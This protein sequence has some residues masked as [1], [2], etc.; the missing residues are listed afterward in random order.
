MREA[1]IVSTARTPIGKA[2][3]GA[4]NMTE[5]PVLGAHVVNAVIERA[6]IDPSRIGDSFWGAGNQWGTQG[7]NVGRMTLFAAGV[8]NSVPAFSLDRKCGSGLTAV[9]M[10]ARAIIC[11]EMDVALAGGMESISLTVTKDAPRHINRS[12]IEHVPHAYMPMIETAEIV[13]ERYHISREAQDAFGAASQQRAVAATD[14]GRLD[15]EIVPITV[16]KQLYEKDGSKAGTETV[17]VSRDEGLRAGTTAEALAG[18]KTAFSPALEVV[19]DRREVRHAVRVGLAE[20]DADL[21]GVGADGRHPGDQHRLSPTSCQTTVGDR[22]PASRVP[23]PTKKGREPS[24]SSGSARGA[25][26]R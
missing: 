5:A 21:D 19:E 22:R 16:E 12:V 25:P 8:P 7:A 26:P 3:R 10:A 18:L 20:P 15:A 23:H 6:G 4:F 24:P 9:A 11:D 13:A 1:A 2:Y 17:A 14:A